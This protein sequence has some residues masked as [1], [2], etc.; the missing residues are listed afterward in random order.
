MSEQYAIL[1]VMMSAL[2]DTLRRLYNALKLGNVY[3]VAM[4]TSWSISDGYSFIY[5]LLANINI[6]IFVM[7]IGKRD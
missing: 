4:V 6:N 2:F 5:I 3:T 1:A 7:K